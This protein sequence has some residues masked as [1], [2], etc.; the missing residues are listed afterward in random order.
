MPSEKTLETDVLVIGAGMAGFFAAMKAKERGLD[1]TLTDKAYAGKAGSTHFSEGDIIYFQPQLG[2]DVKEWLEVIS[3]NSEYLNNREWGE[4]C[5]READDRYRD[6][7]N[8]GVPFYEKDGKLYVFATPKDT[9]VGATGTPYTL[10]AQQNRKFA[11]TLRDKAIACGVRIL[12]RMMISELLEQDGR[13]VGAV[14]FNTISG[15]LYVVKAGATILATGSSSL[16]AGTYPVFSHTGDGEVMAYKVGARIVNKEFMYGVSYFREDVE[17]RRRNGKVEISNNAIDVSY[18]HPFA[19]GGDFSGWYN[20]PNIN[21][22]GEP[23]VSPAWEAHTGKAPLYLDFSSASGWLMKDYLKRIGTPQADKIGLDIRRGMQIKWPSSRVMTSAIWNGSGVWA[24]DKNCSAGI[25]GLYSA[26]NSCGTLAS[27]AV[28]GGM[29]FAST[30]AM[31]TGARAALGAADHVQQNPRATVSDEEIARA[32]AQ[33]RRPF[34]RK[35]GFSPTWV[36]QALHG[37]TVPYYFL[38]IK[39]GE[40]LQAALTLVEFLGTH[41]VPKLMA[42]TPHEWRMAHEVANMVT[43]AEMRFRS[44]LFRTESRGTH[45]RE[46]YPKRSDPDWLAWVK[47]GKT[48]GAMSL[49]REPIPK[50][51]W[52]DLG[53]PREKLYP[54]MLP[55][56]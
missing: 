21:S 20:K 14:G 55:M 22:E 24:T 39:H 51:W 56:E 17:R 1:V 36:T 54:R 15:D 37:I 34:E 18:R 25:P 46:D 12:D 50:A 47:I 2:H 38:D 30:H 19:I 13:I 28:Y 45:F 49:T 8:W 35:G 40:R 9:G 44:S 29:G 10:I 41:I 42:E 26:G 11:P 7:V 53:K 48:D 6:L 43:I 23:V 31:V 4:I 16:K 33:V 27:G 3:R 32:K 52:P 5:L